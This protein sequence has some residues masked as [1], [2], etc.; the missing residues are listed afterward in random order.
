[1]QH[2][3]QTLRTSDVYFVK[4][5][6][7]ENKLFVMDEQLFR[8]IPS[9]GIQQ[10]RWCNLD[11]FLHSSSYFQLVEKGY[12]PLLTPTNLALEGRP[13]TIYRLPLIPLVTE[14][15]EWTTLQW[16]DALK[17]VC[18]INAFLISSGS[19]F[20]A[21]DCNLAQMTFLSGQPIFLDIGGFSDKNSDLAKT[22]FLEDLARLHR[23]LKISLADPSLDFT[24]FSA[25]SW[26]V[27]L[28]YLNSITF[29]QVL[30][31]EKKLSWDRYSL[32]KST[33]LADVLKPS[34]AEAAYLLSLVSS[35]PEVQTVFDAGGSGGRLSFL[36]A[37]HGKYVLAADYS[38]S[39]LSHAYRTNKS[40]KLPVT[41]A[42]IDFVN[43]YQPHDP[44][45]PHEVDN[46]RRRLRCDLVIASSITHHLYKAGLTFTMQAE[47]FA[48]ISSRFI[49]VE[50]IDKEDKYVGTWQL[51]DDYSKDAFL[52]CFTPDWKLISEANHLERGRFWFL[53]ERNSPLRRGRHWYQ[54]DNP[55]L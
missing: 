6:T 48:S 33:S 53:F 36:L 35:L 9:S 49:L 2:T 54:F 12:V 34:D 7:D 55:D 42:V 14:P 24:A 39:A 8:L 16:V 40:L 44:P 18:K 26:E 11:K 22:M 20:L 47:L 1:M 30:E 32:V 29:D 51:G 17:L 41:V 28:N 23:R 3:R 10:N 31:C 15:M 27:A 5:S 46:W 50:Y 4:Q 13:G 25:A 52:R 19:T 21:N 37:A 45:L 43:N 38:A